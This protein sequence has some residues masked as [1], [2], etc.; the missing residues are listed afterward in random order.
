[1]LDNDMT[2]IE[3][4]AIE[5]LE[6][7]RSED[8][9]NLTTDE[10][11]ILL[12]TSIEQYQA[13]LELAADEVD[14][15]LDENTLMRASV[16]AGVHKALA[17]TA[18]SGQEYTFFNRASKASPFDGRTAKELLLDDPSIEN[19]FLVRNYFGSRM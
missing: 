12:A 7:M 14:F 6:T 18:P 3:R 16:L 11:C 9:W 17:S 5:W 1:M 19:L 2:G 8:R 13:W 10:M 15:K 4:T